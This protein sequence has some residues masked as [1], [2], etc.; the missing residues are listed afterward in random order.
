MTPE[1]FLII[2][3]H[4][5]YSEGGASISELQSVTCSNFSAAVQPEES[6]RASRG[7]AGQTDGAVELHQVCAAGSYH[8]IGDWP[9]GWK[10]KGF[11]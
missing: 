1:S 5:D 6:E 3:G 7:R 4:F 8:Y 11:L 2:A 9:C 10:T